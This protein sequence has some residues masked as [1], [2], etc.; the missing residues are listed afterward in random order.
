M[1]FSE[2]PDCEQAESYREWLGLEKGSDWN[3]DVVTP[4]YLEDSVNK[5]FRYN[6][7]VFLFF[8]KRNF[9]LIF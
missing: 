1:V 2:E 6:L 4:E 8:V 9:Y 3:L 5:I 7:V